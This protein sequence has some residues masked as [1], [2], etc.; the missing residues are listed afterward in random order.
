M[1]DGKVDGGAVGNFEEQDLRRCHMQYVRQHGGIGRQWLFQAPRQ[2]A[3]NRHAIAQRGDQYG[4]HQ[5]AVAQ[6]ERLVLRVAVL[7][8]GQSVERRARIDDGGEQ[9]RRRLARGEAGTG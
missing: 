7:V 1:G 9:A 5:R 2:Q 4:A 3:R 8:I 6:V